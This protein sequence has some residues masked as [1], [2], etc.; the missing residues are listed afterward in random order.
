MRTSTSGHSLDDSGS[1]LDFFSSKA[2]NAYREED[3]ESERA[4]HVIDRDGKIAWSRISAI[5]GNLGADGVS[6]RSSGWQSG[7]AAAA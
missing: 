7:T 5:G 6:T 1:E 4:L 2:Y 3:G